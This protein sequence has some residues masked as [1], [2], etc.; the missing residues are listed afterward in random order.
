[1]SNIVGSGNVRKIVFDADDWLGGL[2]IMP[3]IESKPSSSV[4]GKLSYAKA[5]NPYS[6]LGYASPGYEI[7]PKNNYA[8]LSDR[9]V[10]AVVEGNT[11]YST[12]NGQYFI[13]VKTSITSDSDFPHKIYNDDDVI[14]DETCTYTANQ[15]ST[16]TRAIYYSWSNTG[17]WDVGMHVPNTSTFDDDF[18]STVPAGAN[19]SLFPAGQ[20]YEHPLIIGADDILYMGDRRYI[21]QY[22][23]GVG[24]DGTFSEA[25]LT[26]PQDA[27]I[28]SMAK[29]PNYLVIFTRSQSQY[30]EGY[31]GEVKAYFWDYLS[32]DP[33]SVIELGDDSVGGAFNYR[34]TI[35]VFTSGKINTLA[36]GYL[37][38]AKLKFFSGFGEGFVTEIEFADVIPEKGSIYVAGDIIHWL[39]SGNEY[40][41]GS[42]FKDGRRTLNKITYFRDVDYDGIL[43]QGENGKVYGSGSNSTYKLDYYTRAALT[44]TQYFSPGEIYTTNISPNFS[45]GMQGRVK[46][47]KVILADAPQTI[48]DGNTTLKIINQD[49]DEIIVFENKED[50]TKSTIVEYK[51]TSDRMLFTSLKLNIAWLLEAGSNVSP[52]VDKVEVYFEEVNIINT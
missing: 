45:E 49:E 37:E 3:E 18:M 9:L 48:N 31:P 5:F 42:P 14:G 12:T 17:K 2:S 38:N 41:Y 6:R 40:A 50:F 44:S 11:I 8:I 26:L 7:V 4:G 39:S 19:A 21:H 35:G 27:I 28:H 22:D 51:N 36:G 32:Q 25:V 34:G 46:S 10:S 15:S 29:I 20:G 23:G 16:S 30:R 52:Q 1:M 13:E 47:I 43:L 33:T 24:A